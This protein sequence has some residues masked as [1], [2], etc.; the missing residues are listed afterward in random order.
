MCTYNG[1]RYLREQLDSIVNQAYPI[2][3]FLVFDDISSDDTVD[4][5]N[6]YASRYPYM[7]V[8]VNTS[9][10]G[11]TKNFEQAL[12]AASGDVIAISDQDDVWMKDKL[13]R[14]MEVW[15]PEHPLI[16]CNSFIF[17]GH[18]PEKAQEPVFRMFEGT[19]ARKIFLANTIS[20]H[21]IICRKELVPL[22]TPF[23]PSAMYDWWMGV[24]AAYNGGV[25]H[26]DKV[27]V[28][29]RSHE[30][31]QTVNVLNSYSKDD[32]KNVEKQKLIK[33]S[34][35][36]ATAPGIPAEHKEFLFT[37]A[38]LMKESLKTKFHTPLFLFMVKNRKLLFNFKKKKVGIFSHIKHSYRRTLNKNWK[39]QP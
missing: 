4:I 27:L 9:N 34:R 7:K 2:H 35:V 18:V 33:Q 1:S 11:F 24:V 31:N 22:V 29:H 20:G 32:R 36:F 16:Y 14:M 30:A 26:Y 15:K 38:Q 28:F 5:L 10:L 19:D 12:K 37:F 6:N 25:Q 17:S 23:H 39:K 3:E 13:E 21:A 8:Q